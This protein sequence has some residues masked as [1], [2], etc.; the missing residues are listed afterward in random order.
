MKY[1]EILKL[2]KML[3]DA[4]IPFEW[5]E[6][7]GGYQIRLNVLI[8]AIQHFGSYGQEK[9]LIEIMGALTKEEEERDGVLGYLTAEEVFKRFQ[10]C[11]KYHTAV[12][13]EKN[14][15]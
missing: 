8:D 13:K 3:E 14:N 11:Y 6:L 5:K 1:T 12:Y 15:G 4:K 9:D 7:H 2:K 10:Y